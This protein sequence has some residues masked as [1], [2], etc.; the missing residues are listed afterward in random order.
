MGN[1]ITAEQL[2]ALQPPQ[3]SPTQE[4]GDFGRATAER[5]GF[6]G[7]LAKLGRTLAK[8]QPAISRSAAMLAQAGGDEGPMQA[9][10]GQEQAGRQRW[11]DT[12][13]QAIRVRQ[14]KQED[15]ARAFQQQVQGRQLAEMEARPVETREQEATRGLAELRQRLGVQ[16]EF[17]PSTPQV[18]PGG[19]TVLLAPSGEVTRP[20]E[21]LRATPPVAFRPALIPGEANLPAAEGIGAPPAVPGVMPEALRQAIEAGTGA[22]GGRVP[23]QLGAR[24]PSGV[25]GQLEWLQ[26]NLNVDPQ[27]AWALY[28]RAQT[29]RSQT[30]RPTDF[31]KY[32]N[33]WATNPEAFAALRGDK[34]VQQSLDNYKSARAQATREITQNPAFM[35]QALDDETGQMVENAIEERTTQ[36]L[37]RLEARRGVKAPAPTGGGATATNPQ[38]GERVRWDGKQWVRI[39]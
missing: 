26:R 33:L 23:V 7:L 17:T 16:H 32:L 20:F 34:A 30:V 29:V 18:T 39:Q 31:D 2:A 13:N 14:A 9:E 4:L 37:Q 1:P 19:E 28:N 21:T 35:L 10:R 12:L 15:E 11:L 3:W 5:G 36:I 27:T 24:L 6:L 22:P 8:H 25:A 38:T